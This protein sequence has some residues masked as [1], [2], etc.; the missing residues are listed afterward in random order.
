MRSLPLFAGL[1]CLF[2]AGNVLGAD[3][4]VSAG[5]LKLPTDIELGAVSAVAID[6][7]DRV[8]VL[9]RGEPPILAFDADLKYV[10]GWGAGMFKVAHGL[11]VD[12]DDQIW[13][14]DNGN[15]FLRQFNSDGRLLQTV[16]E[17]ANEGK[18]KDRFKS[19]DD[20]V[21]DTAGNMYVADAGN[22]RIVKF[23]AEGKFVT[24]WGGKGKTAG[25]FATTHGLAI[26]AK[27]R[28]YVADRGN[29]RVQVFND[30][31]KHLANWTGFGNPFGLLAVSDQILVSQGDIHKLFLLSQDGKITAQWGD[32]KSL[33]LPH[34]MALNSAGVVFVAEVNGNRVQMFKKP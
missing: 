14:T 15:H 18:A 22:G 2:A 25:K 24:Q 11:R 8:Y 33:Q 17:F 30:S 28:I 32:P 26:D 21:F 12:A 5:F 16:G 20:L 13:T 19:P 10:K 7:K 27:N 3:P 1:F 9:H 31:G 4:Y 6:S 23:D 34:L 29:S